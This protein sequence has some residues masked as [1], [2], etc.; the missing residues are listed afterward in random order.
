MPATLNGRVVAIADKLDTLIGIFGLEMIPSGSSDPF[1]LRRAANGIIAIIWEANL[2]IDLEKLILQGATDFLAA[3]PESPSPV[4]ALQE[5]FMQRLRTLLQDEKNIDYDLI[6]AVLG[7]TDAEYTKR[8]LSDLLDVRDRA[9]FLQQ[10]RQNGKLDAIYETVNRSARL[11]VKGDLDTQALDPQ[12]LINPELLKV[13]Q[14]EPLQA[15]ARIGSQ[16]S[17]RTT[18]AQL[19]IISG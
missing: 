11:A 3:H 8:A 1:A 6:N 4:A 18:T 9:T 19:S 13:P 17:S 2:V 7:D 16:N 14:N 5:F 15:A 10:I 12:D